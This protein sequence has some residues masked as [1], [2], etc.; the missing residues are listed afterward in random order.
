MKIQLYKVKAEIL[1]GEGAKEKRANQEFACALLGLKE[2]D[3]E[4]ICNAEQTIDLLLAGYSF[5]GYTSS[6]EL[7]RQ[8]QKCAEVEVGREHELLIENAFAKLGSAAADW[9]FNEKCQQAQPGLA[10]SS[11]AETML[12]QDACT[13]SLQ[14]HLGEGWRI[15]AIQP[16]PDQRRPDY[17]LGRPLMEAMR[18]YS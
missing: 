4:V 11:V 5:G 13:D 7:K 1:W 8:V 17:I 6:D 2:Q 14:R 18:G 3:G 10:L 16:Q 15:L 12:L 9:A